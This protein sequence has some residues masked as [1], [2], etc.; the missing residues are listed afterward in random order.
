MSRLRGELFFLAALKVKWT[1]HLWALIQ[2]TN[3]QASQTANV[4]TVQ[5]NEGNIKIRMKGRPSSACG[6]ITGLYFAVQIYTHICRDGGKTKKQDDK[7]R[8]TSY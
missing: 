7:V 5:K 3:R 8:P 6:K 1:V 2:I 4:A